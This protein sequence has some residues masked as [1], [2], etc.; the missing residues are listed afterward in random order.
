MTSEQ[1]TSKKRLTFED[2]VVRPKDCEDFVLCPKALIDRLRDDLQFQRNKADSVVTL[3]TGLEQERD[4]LRAALEQAAIRLR[5]WSAGAG[6]DGKLL[7]YID[8]LLAG[9]AVETGDGLSIEETRMLAA[10]AAVKPPSGSPGAQTQYGRKL[11]ERV[12]DEYMR[13]RSA[14]NGSAQ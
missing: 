6:P 5:G 1:P 11:I 12:W 13:M 4:R 7:S 9:R 3:N 2:M 8:T 14:Q 10:L